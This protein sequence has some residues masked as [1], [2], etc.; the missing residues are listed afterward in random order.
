MFIILPSEEDGITARLARSNKSQT[1]RKNEDTA[2]Y[3]DTMV[4]FPLG[5]VFASRTES[6]RSAI[7]LSASGTVNRYI[8]SE[9]K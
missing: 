2:P 3:T 7:K 8:S 4:P 5:A 1:K 9:S 6:F